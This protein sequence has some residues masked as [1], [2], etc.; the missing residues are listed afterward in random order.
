[1]QRSKPMNEKKHEEQELEY[2][3]LEKPLLVRTPRYSSKFEEIKL[4]TDPFNGVLMLKSPRKA[5]ASGSLP[6]QFSVTHTVRNSIR[7]F[8]CKSANATTV[9]TRDMMGIFGCIGSVVNTTMVPIASTFKI[10]AIHVWPAPSGSNPD[11]ADLYWSPS[12]S[13]Y[14]R[15]DEKISVLPTNVSVTTPFT[16]RPPKGSLAEFWQGGQASTIFN[17]MCA[18]GSVV[19]VDADYTITNSI[20]P[21]PLTVTTAAVSTFYYGY[22]DGA[23]NHQFQ[24]V[25]VLSTF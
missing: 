23:T 15:D 4:D 1:M 8:V 13:P 9:T 19:Y 16:F 18:V 2:V 21:T 10:N 7:A 11:S 17:I 22:L 14:T 24:P 20:L 25:G 3:K 5:M 6:P 12:L